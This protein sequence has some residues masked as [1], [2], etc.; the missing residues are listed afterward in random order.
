[1]NFHPRWN[2]EP[3]IGSGMVSV[4]PVF[5]LPTVKAAAGRQLRRMN[6][7]ILLPSGDGFLMEEVGY[8]S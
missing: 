6:P 8:D 4:N 1:M 5:Y 2:C 3:M 7:V